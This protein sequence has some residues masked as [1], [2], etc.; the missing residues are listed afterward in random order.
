MPNRLTQDNERFTLTKISNLGARIIPKS[1]SSTPVLAAGCVV[2]VAVLDAPIGAVPSCC[3]GTTDGV[4]SS[5][6]VPE[7]QCTFLRLRRREGVDY[8]G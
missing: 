3:V 1:Q 6:I 5:P 8:L 4:I 7:I 2:R